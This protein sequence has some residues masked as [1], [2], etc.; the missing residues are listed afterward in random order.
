MSRRP[1]TGP[2]TVALADG[3]AAVLWTEGTT[4][5]GRRAMAQSFEVDGS[6]RGAPVVVSTPEM[7]VIG[8]PVGLAVDGHRVVA[9]FYAAEGDEFDLVAVSIDG[10]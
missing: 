5:W 10:L 3:S 4:E 1:F 7:D 6:P 9:T 2:Q 8:T